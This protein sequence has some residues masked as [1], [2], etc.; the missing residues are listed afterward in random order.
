MKKVMIGLALGMLV[1]C[2]AYKKSAEIK[3]LVTKGKKKIES[4]K[5]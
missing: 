4:L 1:G 5:D 3:T 2:V